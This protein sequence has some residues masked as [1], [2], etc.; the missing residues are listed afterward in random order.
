[1]YLNFSS[2]NY[3]KNLRSP[4]GSRQKQQQQSQQQQQQNQLNHELFQQ[5]LHQSSKL[6][7]PQSGNSIS[8]SFESFSN[9][10]L[11]Q[12]SSPVSTNSGNQLK[13]PGNLN[14]NKQPSPISNNNELAKKSKPTNL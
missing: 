10:P 3:E 6:L 11:H 1:V 5:M 12:K 4:D 9:S 14:L 8:N 13:R 7:T 2:A